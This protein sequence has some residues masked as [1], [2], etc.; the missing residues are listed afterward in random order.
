MFEPRT[1][2]RWVNS[3]GLISQ[4]IIQD[5]SDLYILA[6]TDISAQ[7]RVLLKQY[8]YQIITYINHHPDFAL[9]LKPF[10]QDENA[11]PIINQMI[12]ACTLADVGPMAVVAGAIAEFV[13]QGLLEHCREIIIENGGDIFMKTTRRRTVAIYAGTSPLSGRIGISIEPNT[14][15][16]GICTSSGTVGHSISF[17]TA[18]AAVAISQSALLADAAATALGNAVSGKHAIAKALEIAKQIQG[19]TGALIIVDDQLGA[20]G[21]IQIVQLD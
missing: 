3:E 4:R 13:A 8:R 2:R 20:W 18:D 12:Q 5:E 17:G 19:L 11:A 16:L 15:P 21:N 14:T 9:S 6:D 10:P 1:Y 7:A